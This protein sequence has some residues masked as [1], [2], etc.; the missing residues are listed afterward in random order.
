MAEKLQDSDDGNGS[1]SVEE[2]K[3]ATFYQWRLRHYF[4]VLEEGEKNIQVWC[5]LCAP[6]NKTLVTL[7]QTLG[8]I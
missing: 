2:V 8:R 4:T 5:K 3:K 7:L 6:R 1:A